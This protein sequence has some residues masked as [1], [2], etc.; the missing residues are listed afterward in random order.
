MERG[1]RQFQRQMLPHAEPLEAERMAV[2]VMIFLESLLIDVIG[3]VIKLLMLRK[4]RAKVTVVK[5]RA[6]GGTESRIWCRNAVLQLGL[7]GWSNAHDRLEIA[8]WAGPVMGA[9]DANEDGRVFGLPGCK[10]GEAN[11]LVEG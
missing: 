7:V 10:M 3:S 2:K 4:D 5:K 11:A 9:M 8:G 6:R 1:S